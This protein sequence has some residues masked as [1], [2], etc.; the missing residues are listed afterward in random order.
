[1]EEILMDVLFFLQTVSLLLGA[2]GITLI[3]LLAKRYENAL[4]KW[5]RAFVATF[6]LYQVTNF[7]FF[8]RSFYVWEINVGMMLFSDISLV[9]LL[10]TWVRVAGKVSGKEIKNWFFDKSLKVIGLSYVLA[11]LFIYLYAMD[12]DFNILTTW[13]KA[14]G[15]GMNSI[16]SVSALGGC[17][18]YLVKG[19]KGT[20]QGTKKALL[21]LGAGLILFLFLFYCQD[22]KMYIYPFAPESSG[23]FLFDSISAGLYLLLNILFITYI[24]N[25]KLFNKTLEPDVASGPDWAGGSQ[26][27][28]ENISVQYCLTDREN[29]VLLLVYEGHSNS[30]IAGMLCISPFTVKRHINNIFRKLAV[31]TRMELMQLII[32]AK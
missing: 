9:A 13:G 19:L 2:S 18:G 23:L 7:L 5:L 26:Q 22:L 17:T 10:Y 1:M 8:Y 4:Y 30:T 20:D 25:E 21:T 14:L 12:Q 15:I 6:F 29:E 31:K 24:Y 27:S 32:M 28:I 16:L 11:W 3:V